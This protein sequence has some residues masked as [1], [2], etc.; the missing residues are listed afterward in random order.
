[1]NHMN[2]SKHRNF[3]Q[4][5]FDFQFMIGGDEVFCCYTVPYTYSECLAHLE[6]L[7][8]VHSASP[9]KFLRFGTIGRS[10]AGFDIP[11]VKISNS[12][13]N[14]TPMKRR[15]KSDKE[16]SKKDKGEEKDDFNEPEYSTKPVLFIIGR[17]HCGE[18]HSSFIIHGLI[19]FL[20]SRN[21][22]AHKLREV[23]DWWICPVVNPDGI[24]CGNYRTNLQGK[25]MNRHFFN[26]DDQDALKH[27]R[28]H[29]VEVIRDYLK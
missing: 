29:E 14:Y 15:K 8:K 27:G 13:P 4:L 5:S 9:F 23:F 24:I 17:Q 25:D 12:N 6:E 26:D 22:M 10:I 3:M 7:K 11:I 16:K 20:C 21:I 1:M 19:N 2:P 18:T 28:V